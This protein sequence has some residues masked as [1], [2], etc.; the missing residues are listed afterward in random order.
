MEKIFIVA[1]V[2]SYL[3]LAKKMNK[4]VMKGRFGVRKSIR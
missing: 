2:F 4:K 1:K 3:K